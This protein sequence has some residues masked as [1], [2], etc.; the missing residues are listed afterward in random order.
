M[1]HDF[2]K[3]SIT[4]HIWRQAL[5][6]IVAQFVQLLYNLVD[7]IYIGHL[8]VESG[9]ALT[10]VGITFPIISLITAVINLFGMGGAPLCSIAR[11]AGDEERAE[12]I[13]GNTATLL[14]LASLAIMAVFYLLEEPILFL[15]G[16]SEE[17]YPYAY[18]YMSIYLLG[19]VFVT[20]GTRLNYFIT[21]Q[22]FP[23]IAMVT[24][25]VGAVLNLVLDPVFI[26][27]FDMGV[28]GAAVA[29][30]ISQAVSAV[31]VVR[32]LT[33]KSALL[34]LKKKWLRLR[35]DLVKQI[36]SLGMAGFTM[37]ATNG[38]VQ[39]ACNATL[40]AYSGD[41][42]I[43]IMTILNSVRAVISLPVNG[44]TN[45][46]Q[47]V[48]GFNYGAKLYDRV[49]KGILV[50]TA[51]G[52]IYCVA[53]WVVTLAVP[54]L[55]IRLF[56]DSPEY[57]TAGRTAMRIYFAAF[58]MMV[59]QFSGQSAFV[60]LGKSHQAIFFSLFRKVI[61]VIPLTLLL[62][63]VANLGVT[64]VFLAEPISNIIGGLACYLTMYVTVYRRLG[65]RDEGH[66]LHS[67]NVPK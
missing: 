2:S 3:G 58:C 36:T 61:I 56:L 40:Q 9:L 35:K 50:T 1:E 31:W 15:F 53:A 17:T 6:L 16:A 25:V 28:R 41:L 21:S 37:S 14:F 19:T 20:L 23:R 10:G 22:G 18:N 64:G 11:G 59:F 39:I 33:G 48:L 38:L 57:L 60:G 63:R 55:F 13:M 65:Q 54:E 49:R 29:T 52:G 27:L 12:E 34:R 66:L 51:L 5:P 30:V 43:G 24:V 44:I 7:R 32:F 45:G 46:A 42:Y 67:S 47:P 26:F 4:G 8:P 62:P